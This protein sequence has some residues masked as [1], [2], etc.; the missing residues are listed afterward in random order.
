MED[1]DRELLI[2]CSAGLGS[3]MEDS[4]GKM[5]FCKTDDCVGADHL[6]TF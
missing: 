6:K 3:W 5:V 4:A 2:S 1:F